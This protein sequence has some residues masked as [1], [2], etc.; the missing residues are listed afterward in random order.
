M[1]FQHVRD[2]RINPKKCSFE[3]KVKSRGLD[4]I[5]TVGDSVAALALSPCSWGSLCASRSFCA[6]YIYPPLCCRVW[7]CDLAGSA[8]CLVCTLASDS[9]ISCSCF[10]I[11]HMPT[12][13]RKTFWCIQL[14]SLWGKC[15]VPR[16]LRS[17]YR[18][19]FVG[20]VPIIWGPI[21]LVHSI[22]DRMIS[23]PQ[24]RL[25]AW[26]RFLWAATSHLLCMLPKTLNVFKQ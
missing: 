20:Q 9:R 12:S 7:L 22:A 24:K 1:P 10:N 3:N 25:W 26:N 5:P 8:S 13:F 2:N 19:L 23:F 18:W 4:P 15:F 11:S 16:E 17:H 6:P 21:S 14:L